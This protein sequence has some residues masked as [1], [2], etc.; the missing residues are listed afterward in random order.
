MYLLE[1][2]T[3]HLRAFGYKY[4]YQPPEP[5]VIQDLDAPAPD[6]VEIGDIEEKLGQKNRKE[7]RNPTN[8]MKSYSRFLRRNFY[9]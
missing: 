4:R 8:M 1:Y 7:K 5:S 2:Y 9:K 3:Y 6:K